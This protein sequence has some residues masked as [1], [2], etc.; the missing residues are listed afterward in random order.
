MVYLVLTALYF[1]KCFQKKK[2]VTIFALLI[3]S[4]HY[5]PTANP[6]HP[7]TSQP[8]INIYKTFLLEMLMFMKGTTNNNIVLNKVQT[9]GKSKLS[10]D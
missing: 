3:S 8:F 6:L 9:T 7:H 10:Y 4:T 2:Y 1:N 5:R